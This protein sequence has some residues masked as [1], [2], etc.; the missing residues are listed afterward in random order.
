MLHN[1]KYPQPSLCTATPTKGLVLH[2]LL[3]TAVPPSSESCHTH[4]VSPLC[5]QKTPL[6]PF[7][8]HTTQ[9]TKLLSLT[10]PS[11]HHCQI[12]PTQKQPSIFIPASKLHHSFSGQRSSFSQAVVAFLSHS[13]SSNRRQFQHRGGLS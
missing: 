2:L 3:P 13:N 6:F 7:P 10:A 9:L 1:T 5:C 12:L 8:R 11:H 4:F